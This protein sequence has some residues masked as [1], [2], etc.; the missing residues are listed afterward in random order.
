MSGPR[1]SHDGWALLLEL[2][3]CSQVCPGREASAA[4]PAFGPGRGLEGWGQQIVQITDRVSH[5]LNSKCQAVLF[6]VDL[7]VVEWFL[8]CGHGRNWESTT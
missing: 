7:N 1:E 6:Y 3:V 8:E 2:Q 4:N 5:C